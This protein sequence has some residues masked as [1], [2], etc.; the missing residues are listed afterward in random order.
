MVPCVHADLFLQR[1]LDAHWLSL[2]NELAS[3]QELNTNLPAVKQLIA[4]LEQREMRRQQFI[5][6]P[7]QQWLQTV[8][9]LHLNDVGNIS[10]LLYSYVF[11]HHNA[12]D[13]VKYSAWAFA[14]VVLVHALRHSSVKVLAQQS[15]GMFLL[16][17]CLDDYAV[18]MPPGFEKEIL[19][20]SRGTITPFAV[21][22]GRSFPN[23]CTDIKTVG[24]HMAALCN[25]HLQHL[26]F[27]LLGFDSWLSSLL[28]WSWPHMKWKQCFQSLRW[29]SDDK[30]P[31]EFLATL[32][33]LQ[34]ENSLIFQ[35]TASDVVSICK[36]LFNNQ[37]PDYDM[38]YMICKCISDS[39]E[40]EEIS[41]LVAVSKVLER[42]KRYANQPSA[43]LDVVINAIAAAA[44]L[45]QSKDVAQLLRSHSVDKTFLS[46]AEL[47]YGSKVLAEA[48]E[49]PSKAIGI[50]E[51]SFVL[52]CMLLEPAIHPLEKLV[53]GLADNTTPYQQWSCG[54]FTYAMLTG[55][56]AIASAAHGLYEDRFED[57]AQL[58]DSLAWCGN[59]KYK[60]S[61]VSNLAKILAVLHLLMASS[62]ESTAQVISK[63]KFLKSVNTGPPF[64]QDQLFLQM[65]EESLHIPPVRHLEALLM[66][67]QRMHRFI[68]KELDDSSILSGS[69]SVVIFWSV[70][71]KGVAAALKILLQRSINIADDMRRI[72]Q[73]SSKF[74]VQSNILEAI[75]Y[76]EI[77]WA[78]GEESPERKQSLLWETPHLATMLSS[79]YQASRTWNSKPWLK[80]AM[81][82]YENTKVQLEMKLQHMK[83]GNYCLAECAYLDKNRENF[84][85]YSTVLGIELVK[86][87]PGTT[88]G[89]EETPWLKHRDDF[90][91]LTKDLQPIL[92]WLRQIN[93]GLGDVNED[94][95]TFNS[96]LNGNS[97]LDSLCECMRQ[98][99]QKYIEPLSGRNISNDCCCSLKAT[100]LKLSQASATF[101]MRYVRYCARN[102]L[103]PL[104][105]E[106]LWDVH[107]QGILKATFNKTMSLLN[108]GMTFEEMGQLIEFVRSP[109]FA[110]EVT[111]LVKFF[112]PERD[113]EVLKIVLGLVCHFRHGH[114][115]NLL[116][117]IEAFECVDK[118][119]V[120][121]LQLKELDSV[122]NP[123]QNLAANSIYDNY[124][125]LHELLEPLASQHFELLRSL[126]NGSL[127][128]LV[129][130]FVDRGA[131]FPRVREILNMRF[132]GDEVMNQKLTGVILAREM[133]SAF[134]RPETA[135]M[136][137]CLQSFAKTHH[138]SVPIAESACKHLPC[139]LDHIDGNEQT[140]AEVLKF[141]TTQL[142]ERGR[143]R[144]ILCS[145]TD[146][147]STLE[148]SYSDSDNKSGKVMNRKQVLDFR[149]GLMQLNPFQ[150]GDSGELTRQAQELYSCLDQAEVLFQ[151]WI[152]LETDGHLAAQA[153]IHEFE[154]NGN[155]MKRAIED[156]ENRISQ[157]R[158]DLVRSREDCHVLKLFTDREI[159]MMMALL[160]EDRIRQE[161]IKQLCGGLDNED[162]EQQWQHMA[163]LECGD[164]LAV[165]GRAAKP[166]ERQACTLLLSYF[167]SAIPMVTALSHM[168]ERILIEVCKSSGDDVLLRLTSLCES[169]F[170]PVDPKPNGGTHEQ[171]LCTVGPIS[172]HLI[173]EEHAEHPFSSEFLLLLQAFMALSERLD[174]PSRSQLLLSSPSTSCNDLDLFFSRI[175]TFKERTFIVS[176]LE[177]LSYNS[178]YHLVQLQKDLSTQQD[179]HAR[180]I[181]TTLS[182]ELFR[183]WPRNFLH[184]A[185]NL[186]MHPPLKYLKEVEAAFRSRKV[187]YFYGAPGTGKTFIAQKEA[188]T[189]GHPVLSAS[190]SK[191]EDL[192]QVRR[193]LSALLDREATVVIHVT[194]SLD[195]D[196]DFLNYFFFELVV[197]GIL[198]EQEVGAVTCFR[199]YVYSLYI[200]IDHEYKTSDRTSLQNQIMLQLPVL[201]ATS[202]G[203]EVTPGNNPMQVHRSGIRA[204]SQL[205][206]AYKGGHL[207]YCVLVNS[208]EGCHTNGDQNHIRES[209]ARRLNIP[210]L[211]E[212]IYPLLTKE[213]L[214]SV[215]LTTESRTTQMLFFAHLKLRLQAFL[216]TEFLENALSIPT[217]PELYFKQAVYESRYLCKCKATID[218]KTCTHTFWM[219]DEQRGSARILCPPNCPKCP[220]AL[221]YAGSM[222]TTAVM[223][224]VYNL[225]KSSMEVI[226]NTFGIS[227]DQVRK[228]KEEKAIILSNDFVFKLLLINDRKRTKKPLV[229][230]GD[231]GVGKTFLLTTLEQLW[232]LQSQPD[233]I[234]VTCPWL[235]E[236]VRHMW[237]TLAP[238]GR[239]LF[240]ADASPDYPVSHRQEGDPETAPKTL[241]H[242]LQAC[243]FDAVSL[244]NAWLELLTNHFSAV[245]QQ[246]AINELRRQVS[247]WLNEYVMEL[248]KALSDL[249]QKPELSLQESGELMDFWLA[250]RTKSL[251]FKYVVH[252]SITKED[253]KRYLEEPVKMA[254]DC[255]S[256]TVVIFFDEVNASKKYTSVFKDLIMDR[257]LDGKPV[258]KH[259]NIFFC[260]A[261]NPHTLQGTRQASHTQQNRPIGSPRAFCQPYS[262]RDMPKALSYTTWIYGNMIRSDELR[263]YISAI[264][265]MQ[266][267]LLPL[268]CNVCNRPD[269]KFGD[270]MKNQLCKLIQLAHWYHMERVSERSVSQRDI[271]RVF[272]CTY[273]FWKQGYTCSKAVCEGSASPINT[274]FALM[275]CVKQAV[276]VVYYFRLPVKALR[277]ASSENE[278]PAATSEECNDD[279]AKI[280][281]VCREDFLAYLSKN[282]AQQFEIAAYVEKCINIMVTKENFKFPT[283]V[284]LTPALKE[285]IYCILACI[286]ARIPVPLCIIGHPGTSKTLSFQI[287]RDNLLGRYYSPKEFCKRFHAV[288][289]HECQ[290]TRETTARQLED[291]M[292]RAC[293]R[294]RQY[295]Q[296]NGG[297]WSHSLCVVLL[298]EAGFLCDLPDEDGKHGQMV[299]K[300]LHPFLDKREV[301]FVALSND[302][303]D[304]ANINRMVNVYRD[305]VETGDLLTLA[306][307]CIGVDDI[308]ISDHVKTFL[309]RVC[310]GYQALL[311]EPEWKKFFHHRDLIA[312]FR[313]LR[314]KQ[315]LND[316]PSLAPLDCQEHT[317]LHALEETFGGQ[318]DKK[319]N[320]IIEHFFPTTS[321]PTRR[322][323]LSI[324]ESSQSDTKYRNGDTLIPRYRIFI[325]TGGDTYSIAEAL[326]LLKLFNS[327][328][329]EHVILLA[330]QLPGDGD[331]LSC[332]QLLTEIRR[333]M[334]RPVTLVLLNSGK[335]RVGLYKLFNQFFEVF[336]H[337]ERRVIYT[338]VAV[339]GATYPSE[340]DPNFSCVVLM[341][342]EDASQAPG[343]FLS[344]F[345]KFLLPPLK[346]VLLSRCHMELATEWAIMIRTVQKSL[347]QFVKLMGE[348]QFMGFRRDTIEQLMLNEPAVQRQ[349]GL[350]ELS[351]CSE[352][353]WEKIRQSTTPLLS[354]T[355]RLVRL[356]ACRL[357][358]L[359]SPEHFVARLK[360]L[361]MEGR[362]KDTYFSLYFRYLCHS[363]L[364]S[365]IDML[366]K[367]GSNQDGTVQKCLLY[368]VQAVPLFSLQNLIE[369]VG[370]ENH[371]GSDISAE[372]EIANGDA[373]QRQADADS[374][375]S[376]FM[377]SSKLC[378]VIL[379]D[380]SWM[381]SQE[382]CVETLKYLIDQKVSEQL[383]KAERQRQTKTI[384]LLVHCFPVLHSHS[385]PSASFMNGW[386]THYCDLFTGKTSAILD[387]ELLAQLCSKQCNEKDVETQLKRRV[388]S[389]L[390]ILAQ[391]YC[392]A[393]TH[394]D[395]GDV[396]CA[397]LP[398]EYRNFFVSHMTG[399]EAVSIPT[400]PQRS[401]SLIAILSEHEWIVDTIASCILKYFSQTRAIELLGKL[402]VDATTSKTG[403]PS[404]AFSDF[405]ERHTHRRIFHIFQRVVTEVVS[406]FNL[407]NMLHMQAD[408]PQLGEKLQVL[409]T[410]VIQERLTK[411]ISANPRSYSIKIR[412]S[413][414]KYR[415]PFL[416]HIKSRLKHICPEKKNALHAQVKNCIES[417][418]TCLGPLFRNKNFAIS[419]MSDCLLNLSFMQLPL[420][421]FEVCEVIC[422]YFQTPRLPPLVDCSNGYAPSIASLWILNRKE[423]QEIG[424]VSKTFAHLHWLLHSF[425]M[426]VGNI[427]SGLQSEENE[428]NL[429]KKLARIFFESLLCALPLLSTPDA[430]VLNWSEAAAA[431][432]ACF[433]FMDKFWPAST[434]VYGNEDMD[435][436]DDYF[437]GVYQA[438]RL[439]LVLMQLVD[440]L[441]ETQSYEVCKASL[442]RFLAESRQQS[443]QHQ[444]I[445]WYCSCLSRNVQSPD[446]MTAAL[447]TMRSMLI[448]TSALWTLPE[449]SKNIQDLCESE[450]IAYVLKGVNAS[451]VPC[452]YSERVFRVL[453]KTV[454]KIT[455]A[456]KT[457]RSNIE[458]KL[459]SLVFDQHPDW[460]NLQPDVNYQKGHFGLD[461]FATRR[462]LPKGHFGLPVHAT[463]LPLPSVARG[464]ESGC[465]SHI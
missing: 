10:I 442:G 400:P 150:G 264:L 271:Q 181:Y 73:V 83:S 373:F 431:W 12:E 199:H 225:E 180:V 22:V 69:C 353:L 203:T 361:N 425:K 433:Q 343:A 176:G 354:H 285:N 320:K 1:S 210:R 387:I 381:K 281:N 389:S 157:W 261:I 71:S 6:S 29:S 296:D 163:L 152:D 55:S 100:I 456:A 215:K 369:K 248:P 191:R 350:G 364:K 134:L 438:R 295:G 102:R 451:T 168:Q 454:G 328:S 317:L 169:S 427:W 443:V 26:V 126:Q 32:N 310:R 348:K 221:H 121:L 407:H 321:T 419:Y 217:L 188:S 212:N 117:V 158:S 278:A 463:T 185:V 21:D 392:D 42:G 422:H 339:A 402:S 9:S 63:S 98:L 416:K 135:T 171:V 338:N 81:E 44:L 292:Q 436:I 299:L 247:A 325:C 96:H 363:T 82:C 148:C 459:L 277:R 124:A 275:Q 235:I 18:H 219:F 430:N 421:P 155:S 240:A 265:N 78:V 330:S 197:C 154:L 48:K 450:E 319:F 434:K 307:G 378:A 286:Q 72:E 253:L 312:L 341:S 97:T 273:F 270:L 84:E 138:V 31:V 457:E 355:K 344:R 170:A 239:L 200:D 25:E 20:S 7:F 75:L 380:A 244:K 333:C 77:I 182:S 351:P 432:H 60:P 268:P 404:W 8:P 327:P 52:C 455:N 311:Q 144:I 149:T 94:Y 458:S 237:S 147:V 236:L 276:A 337:G 93:P 403:M 65:E 272:D 183:V 30:N 66:V 440:V 233:Q 16:L 464:A 397:G 357:L 11:S 193:T 345:S 189:S 64:S 165:Q 447:L 365:M 49:A 441:L 207:M 114:I 255:K 375:L 107:A 234:A 258:C 35:P 74:L 395:T 151:H 390:R 331:D 59:G 318:P 146:G 85:A 103:S 362:L 322:D 86:D 17:M 28:A 13:K 405:L 413:T 216:S 379:V 5:I 342:K 238:R 230:E 231:T 179:G 142:T 50:I 87:V 140:Q 336:D 304:P 220:L 204:A 68:T 174:P 192:R 426:D 104:A 420:L 409:L 128:E 99:Q 40:D 460:I 218:W 329:R 289:V 57:L 153:C 196:D 415:T 383:A 33:K 274:D 414:K 266:D 112:K 324:L 125:W 306:K 411:D 252:P 356:L 159:G 251:F 53:E 399:G 250:T 446:R 228:L 167:R 213:F 291:V 323:I 227:E 222:S 256:R 211:S 385:L 300:A 101:S 145:L 326:K 37:P 118:A 131:E 80:S 377:E 89:V 136:K 347:S 173:A 137:D 393:I 133:M 2:Y 465:C 116:R 105:H 435:L 54:V 423:L 51:D 130:Y 91:T 186:P 19:G 39:K 308:E 123:L 129:K 401:E 62:V 4:S 259:E 384:L 177:R 358:Q 396:S 61:M 143:V 394:L 243:S 366:L 437:L 297:D 303:F 448:A 302:F 359:V 429:V 205:Y 453:V 269:L 372:L 254:D 406:D 24:T 241:R 195:S 371:C 46:C 282:G 462:K 67:T 106:E 23:N 119:D 56:D 27:R 283:G 88:P 47:A 280:E 113:V 267:T 374:F 202:K 92:E 293:D 223:K 262:V 444:K 279:R 175:R 360:Y 410:R 209:N 391:E 242:R 90:T 34:V 198:T 190:V 260:A 156:V 305:D 349:D 139:L 164:D 334:R 166:A 417:D 284:A 309:E 38:L 120:Q 127:K 206:N 160:S 132:R 340:V 161:A 43:T 115:S 122:R 370:Q 208:G 224:Q 194:S 45:Y 214:A 79:C 332:N 162:D 439:D 367:D 141:D 14:V 201:V 36:G 301:A 382:S 70:F 229:L 232:A 398:E 316:G 335:I 109:D 110:K 287:V 412:C 314:R 315:V 76:S 178:R 346:T 246:S 263:A 249:V 187:Q 290:C 108:G 418:T 449:K 445:E 245:A 298:D 452:N 95:N 257:M 388:K 352:I 288:D 386:N 461:Q 226:A 294:Q 3:V 313:Y 41:K 424:V 376:R 368:V 408:F 428:D 184:R 15:P 172:S 111:H 58:V